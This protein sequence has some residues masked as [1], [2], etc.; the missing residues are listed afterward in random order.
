MLYFVFAYFIFYKQFLLEKENKN[1]KVMSRK[2]SSDSLDG[3]FYKNHYSFFQSLSYKTTNVKQR[4]HGTY[5]SPF[6][7][8]ALYLDKTAVE[9]KVDD[10][11][12]PGQEYTYI[13]NLTFSFSPRKDDPSCLP[14]AYHSH[15][16]P[17]MEVNAGLLGLLLVCKPG[18]TMN[19]TKKQ[20][21][22][23]G[24]KLY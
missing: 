5:Y 20:G 24:V 4:T 10:I 14:F 19:L 9:D 11:V 15:I 2:T 6:V 18:K 3:R 23:W 13:W 7:P 8:G 12:E 17:D 16:N 22:R 1:E 21:T